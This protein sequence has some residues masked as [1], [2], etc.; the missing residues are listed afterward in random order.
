MD[1]NN[2]YQSF[3]KSSGVCTDT[4]K[5][6]ENCIFFALKGDN[7]NGN[8]YAEEALEKGAMIAVIDDEANH[9]LP[10]KMILVNDVLSALQALAHHH[11]EQLNTPII[12]LTG[13]NVKRTTKELIDD[14]LSEKYIAK[15]TV[16]NVNIHSIGPLTRLAIDPSC[17]NAIVVVGLIHP[18]E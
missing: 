6:K 15:A 2:L 13:S 11:R 5:I 18:G 17:E 14:G 12:G 10:R 7:F 16:G 1:V 8:H 3:L 9:K 4:R